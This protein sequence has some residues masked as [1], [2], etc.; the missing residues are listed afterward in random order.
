MKLKTVRKITIIAGCVI[1][2][3]GLAVAAV[4]L[5]DGNGAPAFVNV[6][7]SVLGILIVAAGAFVLLFHHCPYCKHGLGLYERYCHHCGADLRNE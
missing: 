1:L 3:L 2:A 4:A 6:G 5:V 7:L